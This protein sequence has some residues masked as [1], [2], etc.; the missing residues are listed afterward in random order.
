MVS[1]ARLKIFL[2]Y[3][4]QLRGFFNR[5]C[6]KRGIYAPATPRVSS[7]RIQKTQNE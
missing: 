1:R 3:L 5:F 2:A 6:V 7:I 4:C